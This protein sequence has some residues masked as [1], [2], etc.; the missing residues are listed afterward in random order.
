MDTNNETPIITGRL[1]IL[2][3]EDIIEKYRK[4]SPDEISMETGEIVSAEI[5]ILASHL[6]QL[7]IHLIKCQRE[8]A[9]EWVNLRT[10]TETDGQAEKRAK[11][12]EAY[13]RKEEAELQKE[14]CI[15]VLRALKK[16]LQYKTDEAKNTYGL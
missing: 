7:G 6:Y 15:E 10:E 5:V 1:E 12:T 2:T 3:A 9:S 13:F 14:V 16:L 11:K 8:Y 4:S